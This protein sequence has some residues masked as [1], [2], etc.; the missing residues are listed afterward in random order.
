MKVFKV[1]VM[2]AVKYCYAKIPIKYYAISFMHCSTG[3]GIMSV[4]YYG[5]C[6]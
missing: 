6:I 3:I 2:F 1:V 4:L 5:Y